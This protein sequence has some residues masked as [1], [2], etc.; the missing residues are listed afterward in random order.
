MVARSGAPPR[1][2]ERSV[3]LY[4]HALLLLTDRGQPADTGDL[5]ERVGVS[6]ASASRMLKNLARKKLVRLEP[7]QG[8]ELTAEG[9]HRALR[10]VR[11]HRLIEVFL[12]NVMAFDLGELHRR[13]LLMQPTVDEVFEEKLDA[14]L[15][16][17]T[18]DPHG[19][20]IPGKNVSWPRMSDSVLLELPAGTSGNVSRVTSED[21]GAIEYLEGL[22][23]RAGAAIVL[24][25]VSPFDG[26]VAVRV[27]GHA[28]HL[29]RRLAQLIHIENAGRPQNGPGERQRLGHKPELGA[30]PG[31]SAGSRGQPRRH[32]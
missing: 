3:D 12:H 15:G 24:D 25:G 8:A 6:P 23:V 10:V 21:A 22:G 19:Q 31:L 28:C 5:A 32:G 16:H 27:G 9:M 13:A 7:Y 20:P 18:I 11:R 4:L 26:P 1:S 17:P 14:M 2:R 30:R 29:G